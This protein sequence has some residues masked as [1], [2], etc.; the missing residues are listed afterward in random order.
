MERFPY[1]LSG[2]KRQRVAIARAL[3]VEPELII[4]DEATS[5]LDVSIQSRV[6]NLP[7]EIQETKGGSYLFIA[8]DLA[9]VRHISHDIGVLY[10]G[11]L[12]DTG[13][14][15]RV[16]NDAAHSYTA[17]LLAAEPI[18]SRTPY[19]KRAALKC[20]ACITLMPN[21]LAQLTCHR[22]VPSPIAVHWS[23]TSV[24]KR[25][26]RRH[27]WKEAGSSAAI[28]TQSGRC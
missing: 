14:A 4:C 21:R 15:E 3:S 26:R 16:Y 5:A 23:W 24:I 27:L 17:M 8:H 6:I 25:C 13:P 28:Y 22:I 20:A 2:G 18:Q 9:V 10:L 19:A 1:E 11:Y 7:E 12:V